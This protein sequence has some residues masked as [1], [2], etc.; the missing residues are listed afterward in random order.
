MF[1]A[2]CVGSRGFFKFF[3]GGMDYKKNRVLKFDS[4]K[5]LM[6]T[7]ILNAD[8]LRLQFMILDAC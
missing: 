5:F 8:F 7:M 6:T 4:S 2:Y 3:S 1:N